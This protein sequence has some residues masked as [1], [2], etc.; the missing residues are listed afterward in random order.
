VTPDEETDA[1]TDA[2]TET[3]G[4]PREPEWRRRRRLAAV[5][6]EEAP[7]QTGDD[8]DPREDRSGKDDDWYRQQ[9]PPHHG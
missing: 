2:E 4:T 3:A 7:D 9:V 5:F 8:R 1:A 6:G